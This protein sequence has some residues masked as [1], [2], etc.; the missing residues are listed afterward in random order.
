MDTLKVLKDILNNNSVLSKILF[1]PVGKNISLNNIKISF[2]ELLIF[3]ILSLM[4]LYLDMKLSIF[5]FIIFF[6]VFL[7]NKYFIL[8]SKKC[9]LSSYRNIKLCEIV[10]DIIIFFSLFRLM[11]VNIYNSILF[12]FIL[13]LFFLYFYSAIAFLLIIPSKIRSDFKHQLIDINK[14]FLKEPGFFYLDKDFLYLILLVL[15]LVFQNNL[16]VFF[17]ILLITGLFVWIIQL[18]IIWSKLNV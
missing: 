1:F 17:L 8:C 11:N 5:L 12:A 10:I 16:F 3:L 14:L 6:F 13:L 9:T 18:K 7:S 2:I 15:L 4:F